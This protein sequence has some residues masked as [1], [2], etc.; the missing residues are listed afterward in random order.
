MRQHTHTQTQCKLWKYCVLTRTEPARSMR[1]PCLEW[2]V[3]WR[4]SRDCRYSLATF[5][6]DLTCHIL[7]RN[8]ASSY[9][10][11]IFRNVSQQMNSSVRG[12]FTNVINMRTALSWDFTQQI[13]VIPYRRFGTTWVLNSRTKST[14]NLDIWRWDWLSRN[15]SMELP[16]L[17]A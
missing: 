16:L 4:F 3:R 12:D 8:E 17:A 9:L 10:R 11:P 13:F 5:L 15:V 7:S 2:E 1:R 6:F 14:H